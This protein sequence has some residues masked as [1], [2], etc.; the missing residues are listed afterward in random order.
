MP[1]RTKL[2]ALLALAGFVAA[3]LYCLWLWQPERQAIKHQQTLLQAA[4]K[5]KW[6]KVSSLIAENYSDR[7][8]F[9]K[10]VAL[11]ETSEVLRQF[12][13]LEIKGEMFAIEPADDTIAIHQRITFDGK[14]TALAEMA[15][16]EVNN[17]RQPFRFEWKRQS[18]KPWDWQLT[19][20]DHPQL[21]AR[22]QMF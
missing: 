9:S 21:R 11:R 5:R 18:W 10:T 4:G 12:F 3:A 22:R 7:W 19:R 6:K 14:G 2:I 16:Q 13:V 20:V 15:K 1:S 8:G 17:L